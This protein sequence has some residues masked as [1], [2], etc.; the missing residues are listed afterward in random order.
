VLWILFVNHSLMSKLSPR[1]ET[2]PGAWLLLCSLC[3]LHHGL[4]PFRQFFFLGSIVSSCS[5]VSFLGNPRPI[6]SAYRW[7]SITGQD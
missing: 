5:L 2:V 6:K 7:T 3:P 1:D 4:V